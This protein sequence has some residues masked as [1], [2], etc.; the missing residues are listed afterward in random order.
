MIL[1]RCINSEGR[2]FVADWKKIKAEY[3]KGGTS[4]RELAKKHGVSFTTLTRKA[5]KEDWIGLR[6]QADDKVTTRIV[7]VVT[8]KGA[9]ID[10]TYYRLVDKLMKKVEDT[11]D[12]VDVWSVTGLKDMSV[13]LKNLK[14]CKGIRSES[15]MREQEARIKK[16]EREAQIGA[17]EDDEG[18]GV[19]MLPEADAPLIDKEDG[20]E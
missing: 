9:E 7:D 11:I 16:L 15:D 19:L 3:I 13:T 12:G 17:D 20:G 8:A 1:F 4:Y 14:E 18:T 5:Q 10:S 6:Q 2:L